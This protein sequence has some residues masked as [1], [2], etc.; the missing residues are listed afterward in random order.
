MARN[1][2]VKSQEEL[3]MQGIITYVMMLCD[4]VLV[5]R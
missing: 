5:N 2:V 1:D 3:L 4:G